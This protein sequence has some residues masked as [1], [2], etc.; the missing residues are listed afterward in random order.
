MD[1]NSDQKVTGFPSGHLVHEFSQNT[2][3]TDKWAVSVVNNCYSF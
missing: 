2:I 3:V 1:C